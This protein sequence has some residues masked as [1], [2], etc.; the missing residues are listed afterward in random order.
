MA[1]AKL[2]RR[3]SGYWKMEAANVLLVPGVLIML[4]GWTPSWVLLVS[5]VPMMLLLVIGAYYWRAKLKQMED[6]AYPFGPTMR[7]ISLAQWPSLLLTLLG[8]AIV[9]YGWLTPGSFTGAWDKGGATF[10]AVLAGLEYI[11]YY[12]R[13][14]Q[15]FDHG[16]DFKRLLAGKG[17]RPSQMA[18][19]LEA[20]RRK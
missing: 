19:D 9:I 17:L 2:K 11:N 10:S 13:Q 4:T 18:R 8:G 5:F 14:L 7:V 6:R 15:H 20:Y 16:P 1:A 3:L 12:H